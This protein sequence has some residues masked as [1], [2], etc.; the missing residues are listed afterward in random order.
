MPL[1][2]T[3]EDIAEACILPFRMSPNVVLEE[4][5][6]HTAQVRHSFRHTALFVYPDH[7]NLER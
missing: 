2:I 4:I 3:P 1:E 7:I 6:V 5:I